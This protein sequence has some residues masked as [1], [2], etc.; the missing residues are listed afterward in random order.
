[1][2]DDLFGDEVGR[3]V[4][5]RQLDV[6]P[7]PRAVP[8]GERGDHGEGR[9]G[10][11]ERIA[12]PRDVGRAVPVAGDPRQSRHLLHA[13]R[14]A[15]T[16]PPRAV[17]PEAGH[18][19]H[20]D[21]GAHL[22][23]PVVGEVELLED[24][25]GEVLDDDV[26]RR[27]QP[28]QQLTAAG[29]RQVERDVALVE[30]DGEVDVAL[31][32]PAVDGRRDA[33]VV[34]HR[35][36]A[37]DG[38]DLDHVGPGGCQVVGAERPGQEGGEVEDAHPG[39]RYRHTRVRGC[40]GRARPEPGRGSRETRRRRAR[41][42]RGSGMEAIVEQRPGPHLLVVGQRLAVADGHDRDPVGGR[43]LDHLGDR[44]LAGPGAD[45]LDDVR[46]VDPP[47]LDEQRVVGG[48]VGAADHREEGVPLL[49]GDRGDADVAVVA[50]LDP[51]HHEEGRPVTGP[52]REAGLHGRVVGERDRHHLQRRHVHQRPAP[53]RERGDRAQRAVEADG[54]PGERP[55]D[56]ERRSVR[57]AVGHQPA[58]EGLEE[59]LGTGLARP[60]PGE[61]EV[62][63]AHD[64]EPGVGRG[65]ADGVV[66]RPHHHDVCL[67]GRIV[68]DA[69]VAG[70]EEAPQGAVGVAVPPEGAGLGPPPERAAPRRLDLHDRRPGVAEELGAVRAGEVP[71]AVRDP[72]ALEPGQRPAAHDRAMRRSKRGPKNRRA[73][74][75]R[76]SSRTASG[77]RRWRSRTFLTA[78]GYTASK[79]G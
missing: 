13:R 78:P 72:D 24:A 62:G 50:R 33:H 53:G 39:E 16:V 35:V 69:A 18:A 19:H 55:A 14:K 28:Q 31:V 9:V 41:S 74:P 32:E 30:V 15:G 40:G 47:G 21:V 42:E 71:G 64:D 44:V 26:A 25:G 59:E 67:D 12:R 45:R 37:L 57:A 51:R 61:P 52:S 23:E 58:G 20:D 76:R 66:G 22:P 75:P 54:P 73:L 27:R 34:S 48:E 70:G 60:R 65:Q 11:G 5:H 46:P 8:V 6:L 17:E 38:L 10:A 77:R 63:V 2:L 49:G 3:H 1:M 43:L 4:E 79:C 56:H 68:D 7:L 29:V 36:R